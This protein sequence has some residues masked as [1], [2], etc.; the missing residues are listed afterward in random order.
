MNNTGSISWRSLLVLAALVEV[1][2]VSGSGRRRVDIDDRDRSVFF[3]T[4][5]ASWSPILALSDR[6]ERRRWDE[7]PPPDTEEARALQETA[8]ARPTFAIDFQLGDSSAASHQDVGGNDTVRFEDLDFNGPDRLRLNYDMISSSI[9]GR[10]GVLLVEQLRLEGMLGLGVNYMDLKLSSPAGKEDRDS[11]SSL[12]PQQGLRAAWR[13]V[14]FFSAYA[15]GSS[16]TGL[17]FETGGDFVSILSGELGLALNPVRHLGI[18][19]AWRWQRYVQERKGSDVE[20]DFSG[21]V[22]GLVLEL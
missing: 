10:G 3:P 5:R 2:C 17:G 21:P 19:W 7:A 22:L 8:V 16:F 6:Y 11:T 15:Q 13:P 18:F 12:G 14:R 4:L 20:L 9:G 1:S